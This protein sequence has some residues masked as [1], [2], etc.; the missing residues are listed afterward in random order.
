MIS[1]SKK[2]ND[3]LLCALD[4]HL[5]A[6]TSAPLRLHS[7]LHSPIYFIIHTGFSIAGLL[8][9]NVTWC[10]SAVLCNGGS[11]G[12]QFVSLSGG[13]GGGQVNTNLLFLHSHTN[14]GFKRFFKGY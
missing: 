10:L 3:K 7:T 5:I 12:L 8:H 6:D 11:G 14:N 2:T 1:G 9:R 13:P 4:G